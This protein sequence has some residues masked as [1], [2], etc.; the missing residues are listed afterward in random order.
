M[1][2]LA[3]APRP[4]SRNR[5]FFES[6]GSSFSAELENL[7]NGDRIKSELK[8]S[9]R[10]GFV[11]RDFTYTDA[12]HI[13]LALF[14]SRPLSLKLL[15]MKRVSELELAVEYLP[16]HLQVT[17]EKVVIFTN[18]L[19][20]TKRIVQGLF[21]SAEQIIPFIDEEGREIVENMK[22]KFKVTN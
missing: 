11:C 8:D 17:T 7:F 19:L 14:Q 4:D 16:Q 1:V 21:T 22:R 18:F 2:A 13:I 10:Y 5:I 3:S 9:S 20:I 6:P 15:G 12:L